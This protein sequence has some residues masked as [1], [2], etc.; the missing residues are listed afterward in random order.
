MQFRF[1]HDTQGIFSIERPNRQSS[2][3]VCDDLPG[4]PKD[5]CAVAVGHGLAVILTLEDF[6]RCVIVNLHGNAVAARF[7]WPATTR[8]RLRA[9]GDKHLLAF[10]VNGRILHVELQSSIA[11]RIALR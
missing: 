6:Q 9:Q 5:P 1:V 7:D 11:R 4:I 3:R 8:L 10:D 2:L